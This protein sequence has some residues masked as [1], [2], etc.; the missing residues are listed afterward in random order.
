MDKAASLL[1]RGSAPIAML[2]RRDFVRSA[3][4]LSAAGLPLAAAEVPG[5]G[6]E[7][8]AGGEGAQR[9]PLAK[10][11]QWEELGYGMFLHFGMST[12]TGRELPDGTAPLSA[13]HPTRLDVDQWLAAARDAGMTYAV[14]TAKH[15]AGHCLW[16]SKWTRYHVGNGPVKTDVVGAFAQA[17]ARHGLRAALY[18]CSWDNH[19]RFGSMTP[20]DVYRLP[21]DQQIKEPHAWAFQAYTTRAYQDF[22]WRQIEELMTQYGPLVEFWVDIPGVLPR[23]YREA[24]YRQM[25]AWQPGCAVMMNS[26]GDPGPQY[27]VTYSWP[28]DLVA[29]ERSFPRG[30]HGQPKW[31]QIEGKTYY[32]PA[33]CC[34]TLRQSWFY[35]EGEEARPDGELLG[36]YLMARTRGCNF[37]LDVPP[38]RTGR[39]PADSVQALQR[40]RRAV[41]RAAAA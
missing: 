40:L 30:V 38:D 13:Y 26:G 19:N 1:Q 41:D 22:Q 4:L 31:R 16:P 21:P 12:F 39:I 15:V 32:L 23:G 6:E 7:A 20:S 24:L 25:A 3:L 28:S 37:L 34:D 35:V 33:E 18:Y 17:C 9:L 10:L 2:S 8:P 11:R 27:P 5:G 36:M 29:L 14:L